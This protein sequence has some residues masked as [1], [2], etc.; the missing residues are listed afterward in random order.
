M[1]Q[2]S[3]PTPQIEGDLLAARALRISNIDGCLYSVMVGVSESL[4]GAMAVEL[5]HRDAELALIMTLPM[6]IGSLAQL[7]AGPLTALLGGRKRLVVLGASLQAVSVLGFYLIAAHGDRALMPILVA[8]TGYFV[9]T[10]LVGPPWG[11]W[12]AALTENRQRERYF[13]RRTAL[14][15]VPLLLAF[16]GAGMTLHATL[17]DAQGRLHAFAMLHLVGFTFRVLSTVMLVLQPDF[18]VQPRTVRQ[19][20]GAIR[21]AAR[22]GDFRVPSYLAALALATHVAAPF[23]TP[24]M[25]KE[26]HLSYALYVGL[27]A[28]PIIVKVIFVPMLHPLSQRFGMRALLSWSGVGVIALPALWVLQP[29]LAG[30]ALIQL[31]S[32]LAW[33]TVE[34]ASYQLLLGSARS[35]CRV[36]FLSL[37]TAMTS[38][39]Q[40]AGG[41]GGGYLRT[42]QHFSYHALFLLSATGRALALAY[43]IEGLPKRLRYGVPKLFLRVIS[44]RP[45]FGTILRPIITDSAQKEERE[46]KTSE[47]PPE[48]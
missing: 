25:L 13:A 16:G 5:G 17:G 46:R 8:N 30:L 12:M 1:T 28:I 45:D 23:F 7:C 22:T 41:L 15:Q 42:A 40:L 44:I 31:L 3:A 37:A 29:G 2:L 21:T 19:S 24:Y 9:C 47:P 4:I 36:E 27:T 18:N 14:T 43:T 10:M 11:S 26:L 34:Y 35:D 6:L 32:G 20:V 38:T 48:A 39:A 33:G